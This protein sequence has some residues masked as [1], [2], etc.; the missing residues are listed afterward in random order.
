MIYRNV[1]LNISRYGNTSV[2]GSWYQY[3]C[4]FKTKDGLK[5]L[6]LIKT[7]IKLWMLMYVQQSAIGVF[8]HLKQFCCWDID[9]W[10]DCVTSFMI[11]KLVLTNVFIVL[12]RRRLKSLLLY[13]WPGTG[14][15]WRPRWTDPRRLGRGLRTAG[16][17]IRSAHAG[18]RSEGF[19]RI[20]DWHQSTWKLP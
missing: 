20:A 3:C 1:T 6:H 17:Q 12:P 9:W 15:T 2:S 4:D 13:S 8:C 16:H 14:L 10:I 7:A 5:K 19:W 18:V 11:S